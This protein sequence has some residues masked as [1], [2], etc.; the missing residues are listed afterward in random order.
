MS[1][2]LEQLRDAARWRLLKKGGD[3]SGGESDA[4]S[5]SL[6]E[7]AA[8]QARHNAAA[9]QSDGKSPQQEQDLLEFQSHLFQSHFVSAVAEQAASRESAR[10]RQEAGCEEAARLQAQ[11]EA[12]VKAA[13]LAGERAVQDQALAGQLQDK[14]AAEEATVALQ[15]AVLLPSARP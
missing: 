8:A 10:M 2:L 13:A 6:L 7:A 4:R 14:A 12:D 9:R 1:R 15:Q 3:D 5:G 11:S